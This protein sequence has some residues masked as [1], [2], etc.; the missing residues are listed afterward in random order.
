MKR[1][2][3]EQ[4]KIVK[5]KL[6]A[7]E[8]QLIEMQALLLQKDAAQ[9]ELQKQLKDKEEQMRKDMLKQQV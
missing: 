2:L 7:Q 8:A 9:E 6:A 4:D 1:K 3:A 5:E